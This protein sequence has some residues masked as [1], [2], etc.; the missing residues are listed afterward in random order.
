MKLKNM[1]EFIIVMC[2]YNCVYVEMYIAS[3]VILPRLILLVSINLLRSTLLTYI[4]CPCMDTKKHKYG[5]SL[6]YVN[7]VTNQT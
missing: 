2:V 7:K 3:Y 4:L 1:Y 6:K 5:N